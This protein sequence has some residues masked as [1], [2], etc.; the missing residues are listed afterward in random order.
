VP[1]A[2]Q[3][4]SGLS[5]RTPESRRERLRRLT[6]FGELDDDALDQLARLS[7]VLQLERKQTLYSEGAPYR[8]MFVVLEGLAV[9]YK[10]SADGRML[11][12]NVCR[13]GATLAEVPLFEERDA[14]YPAHARVTRQSEILF[15]PRESFI[16][17]LKRHPSVAWQLLRGFAAQIKE[18]GLRLE[19]VTLREVSSRVAQY[20]LREMEA[21][22][23][24]ESA[25]ATLTLPLA[26]GSIA[27]YLG[28]VHE[29]LS[30]TLARLIREKIVAVDGA[31]ITI[32]DR[33][34]LERLV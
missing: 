9:V 25:R 32:L 27:S 28:T 34:R 7:R 20:L 12:L 2:V 19:G 5:E 1:R 10:L 11:I 8:G 17:F 22:G 14:G 4:G 13:P 3:R 16:P 29:T 21:A 23:H 6:L 30:R 33:E 26:K 24:G 18:M 31:Q 15:L